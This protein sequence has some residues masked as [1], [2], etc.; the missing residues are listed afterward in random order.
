MKNAFVK[1]LHITT[2]PLSLGFFTG[3]VG[4]MRAKGL[5]VE[6]LAS[7]GLLLDRFAEREN[8][9][10]HGVEMPRRIT[11]WHDL[12]AIVKVWWRLRRIRPQI[13]HAHTP[14]GDLLGMIAAWLARVPVRIYHI[15]GLPLMTATGKKRALLRLSERVACRL[16]STLR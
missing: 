13:V 16:A 10:V 11:P 4:Y 9:A 3:Q 6:A 8:I 5:V 7:P 15:H 12:I 1:L 2:V 14:K